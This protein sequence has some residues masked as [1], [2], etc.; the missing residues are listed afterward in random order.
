MHT[1]LILRCLTFRVPRSWHQTSDQ[2]ESCDVS[3]AADLPRAGIAKGGLVNEP[4]RLAFAAACWQRQKDEQLHLYDFE[5]SVMTAVYTCCVAQREL[6]CTAPKALRQMGQ[7]FASL[8]K[9]RRILRNS[10][11]TCNRID[12]Q[13][14]YKHSCRV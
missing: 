12:M 7:R 2:V 13:V 5:I 14:V 4:S 9:H 10:S 3:M 8:P 11:F 1:V 6:W